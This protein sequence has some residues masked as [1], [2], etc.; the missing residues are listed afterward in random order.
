[1]TKNIVFMNS[2]METQMFVFFRLNPG[3]ENSCLR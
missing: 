2:F 3:S 1:M